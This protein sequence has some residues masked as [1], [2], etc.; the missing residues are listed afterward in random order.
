MHHK[1]N[2]NNCNKYSKINNILSGHSKNRVKS[3]IYVDK[4][5]VFPTTQWEVNM[6]NQYHEEEKNKNNLFHI[7]RH[8]KKTKVDVV[9]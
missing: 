3:I 8:V 6:D 9:F 7:K 4:R 1:L 2:P 5:I